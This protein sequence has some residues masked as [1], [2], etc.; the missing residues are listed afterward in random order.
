M[1]VRIPTQDVP[2]IDPSTGLMS[3]DWYDALKNLEKLG[4][5]DLADVPNT[6]TPTNGQQPT[7]N[8]A[9]SKWTWV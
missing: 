3:V 4:L 9:T 5:L 6:T 2:V 8:T 1:K 7:W